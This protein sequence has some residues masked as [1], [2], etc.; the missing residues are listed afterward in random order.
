MAHDWS[1]VSLDDTHN[2]AGWLFF[3]LL[4]HGLGDTNGLGLLTHH[5]V[6]FLIVIRISGIVVLECCLRKENRFGSEN[7]EKRLVPS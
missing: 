7:L 1:P 4:C 6:I 3:F 5:F 2:A